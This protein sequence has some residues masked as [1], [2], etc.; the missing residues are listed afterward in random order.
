MY[1]FKAK[2]SRG[3]TRQEGLDSLKGLSEIAQAELAD[4]S[5]KGG[6]FVLDSGSTWWEVIQECYVAPEQ[7]KREASGGKRTGGLEYMQG[8]LIVNGVINWL[9][10][11]GVFVIITHRKR[12]DW[13]PQGPIPGAFSA[14]INKKVPY[15]VEIRIDLTK[16][17]AK[18]G[19]EECKAEG[20]QGRTHRARFLKFAADT[21]YE[22]FS[23]EDEAINFGFV[24]SLYTGKTFPDLGRLEQ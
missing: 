5:M 19:G 21:S 8:N 17:C 23:F 6:T 4:G 9:T 18:C 1:E 3:W 10:S 11:Q 7:E 14:Q 16:V 2:T 22:G 24:Y 12:Q 13:G 15:L 20:H